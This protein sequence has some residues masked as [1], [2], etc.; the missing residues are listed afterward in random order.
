MKK[1]YLFRHAKSDKGDAVARDF[2]RPLNYRGTKDAA[3]VGKFMAGRDLKPDLVVSSPAERAKQTALLALE[4]A[5][6]NVE[7]RFD[8]RIY[9][10]S[11]AELLT[12]VRQIED[13]T[14]EAI[15]VGHNP[16]F[17]DLLANLT[18]RAQ[19]MPTAALACLALEV[20]KWA[21]V[22]VQSAELEWMIS[23]NELEQQ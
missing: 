2:D 8:E 12:V 11:S 6:L 1:L 17:E 19:H 13:A 15:L 22:N 16:G 5:Q 7:L 21:D 23:P 3:L 10:A 20:E 14:N 9:E 4:A 18:G